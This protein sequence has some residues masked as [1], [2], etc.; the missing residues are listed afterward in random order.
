MAEIL[1]DIRVKTIE[2]Q[3]NLGLNFSSTDPRISH[4]GEGTFTFSSSSSTDPALNLV[5]PNGGFNL[6][7]SK[8][9]EIDTTDD[10]SGINIG[11]HFADIPINI[12]TTGSIINLRDDITIGGDLT[13]QGNF[14]VNGDT[15]SHNVVVFTSEDP[16]FYLNTGITGNNT[17]DIGFIG[18]RGALQNVGWFWSEENKEWSAIGTDSTGLTNLDTTIDNYKPIKCGGLNVITDI[19]NTTPTVCN[20]DINGQIELSTGLTGS[21]S[22]TLSTTTGGIEINTAKGS[23]ITNTGSYVALSVNQIG[24]ADIVNFKDNNSS[25]LIVKDGGNVGIGIDTPS[26]KLDVNGNL[27]STGIY[28]GTFLLV[29]TGSITA[30]AGSSSPDGWLICDGSSLLRSGYPTLFAVLG[31]TYGF[32]D[33]THFNLP[34]M[35]GKMVVGLNSADGNFDALGETGGAKNVTLTTTELPSHTHTG[36]TDS[37]GDHTHTSNCDGSS[38]SLSTYTGNN[39][40]NASINAGATE[41]DLYAPQVALSINNAGS[42]THTFTTASTGSGSAFSVMNPYITLNY[43][44]KY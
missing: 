10:I 1:D 40:M 23:V 3:N 4:T 38:Y 14:T 29:P 24:T 28:Q 26:Y 15:V 37:S 31:T 19:S 11:T 33:G 22:I 16:V 8:S 41:P 6:D 43:I 5:A 42:H 9:I 12:G 13:V 2:I 18:D 32:V 36:T 35:K 25:A 21:N 39:T 27:N 17:S 30:F 7:V 44:I 34:N 20:V